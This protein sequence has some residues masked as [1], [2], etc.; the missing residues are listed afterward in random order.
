MRRSRHTGQLG[1]PVLAQRPDLSEDLAG[2]HYFE[3][4]VL[5]GHNKMRVFQESDEGTYRS[6]TSE[7]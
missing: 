1:L 6:V 2:G 3:P 7:T 4:T 5:R